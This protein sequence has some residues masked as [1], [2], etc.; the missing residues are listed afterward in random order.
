MKL[1]YKHIIDGDI[2]SYQ[3]IADEL[4]GEKAGLKFALQACTLGELDRVECRGYSDMDTHENFCC[5][6][7]QKEFADG[8]DMVRKI[9]ADSIEV[10][11]KLGDEEVNVRVG[12]STKEENWITVYGKEETVKKVSATI[13]KM[14]G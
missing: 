1:A 11:L 7:T 12:L 13:Q 5:F 6:H 3:W 9:D 14:L 2:V 4:V 8:L 10:Y